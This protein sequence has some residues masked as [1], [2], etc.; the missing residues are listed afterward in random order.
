MLKPSSIENS[1]IPPPIILKLKISF[2]KVVV[3]VWVIKLSHLN[4]R[5]PQLKINKELV[6]KIIRILPR[7]TR[8]NSE[9]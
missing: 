2:S 3:Q 5:L 7:N 6:T 8:E 4:K 9:I 1:A